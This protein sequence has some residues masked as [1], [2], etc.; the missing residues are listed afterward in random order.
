MGAIAGF[1]A[2]GRYQNIQDAKNKAQANIIA[3]N[4][5]VEVS[6]IEI[7]NQAQRVQIAK[8]QAEIRLQDAIGVREA[9]DEIAKTLT[10][11]YVQYEMTQ[12]L[13]R[14]AESGKNN[15]V[16]YVPSGQ[17]GIPTI[18]AQAGTGK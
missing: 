4:N 7:Q 1:Q 9:Q 16:V 13:E 11:I 18:T 10:P 12:A 15:T 6:N 14:I 5:Q 2:F 17:G 3:A 8:Q